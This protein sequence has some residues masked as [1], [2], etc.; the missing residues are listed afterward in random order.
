MAASVVRV[1]VLRLGLDLF[2][3]ETAMVRAM[4]ARLQTLAADGARLCVFPGLYGLGLAGPWPPDIPWGRIVRATA[5][6]G[7]AFVAVA[8]RAARSAHVYLVP[9]SILLPAGGDAFVEWSGVFDPGGQLLGEQLATQPNAAQPELSPDSRLAPIDTPFG[10]VGLLLGADADV[11][12]VARILTLAG[13]RLLIAPRAPRAPYSSMQAMAGL[14]QMVQQNQVFG[15]ESGL[16]GQAAGHARDGKAGVFAPGE[17]TPGRSGFL[18]RPG[19]YVGDGALTADLDFAQLDELRR[20]QPLARHLNAALYRRH[21]DAF[22]VFR[23]ALRSD[24]GGR[25]ADG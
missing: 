1:S 2:V 8:A 6:L 18:G 22:G 25:D 12:D 23:P 15:L 17:L 7:E 4:A 16:V 10:A 11:P 13:A 19:F 3:D 5:G 9:G 14:W 24:G 20:R 21:A